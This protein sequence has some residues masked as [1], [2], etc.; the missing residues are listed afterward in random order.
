MLIGDERYFVA[1]LSCEIPMHPT[2]NGKKVP[3]LLSQTEID[4]KM[5]ENEIAANRE[6]YNIFDNFNL[7]DSVVSRSDMFVNTESFIPGPQPC[8]NPEGKRNKY[9][10]T[11]D[12]ASKNDN[13]P[14]LVMEIYREM[15]TNELHGRCVYMEN[16]VVT[17][18]DG[19]KRPMRLDEQT[20]RLRELIYIFNG[21]ENAVPYENVTV[22]ID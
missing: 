2:V 9:V 5:R 4:R 13:A 12:P 6:Y 15:G 20:E 3:A 22:L 19:S 18:K 16:F 10:I 7:E 17:Y 11:Y 21:K 8:H 14:V 1:D